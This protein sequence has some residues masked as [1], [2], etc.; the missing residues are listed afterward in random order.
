MPQLSAAEWDRLVAEWADDAE[1]V[2]DE[3][4]GDR[5]GPRCQDAAFRADVDLVPEPGDFT[6]HCSCPDW[7][8]P[9]KHAAALGYLYARFLDDRGEALLVLH[10]RKTADAWAAVAARCDETARAER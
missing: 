9:C 4:A 8:D 3:L 7:G 1:Q 6:Y 2:I 10:G 5:L